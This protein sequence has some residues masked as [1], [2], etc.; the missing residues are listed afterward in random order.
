MTQQ[1]EV[2]VCSPTGSPIAVVP[3]RDGVRWLDEMN[4]VGSGQ[5]A[6][7]LDDA[8][9]ASTP[10]ILDPFNVVKL[11][12]VT[13]PDP[14]FAFQLENLAPTQVSSE[15]AAGRMLT[16]SGRHIRSILDTAVVTGNGDRRTF[17]FSSPTGAWYVSSDWVTPI[18][19]AWSADSTARA[20]N[21]KDWPDPT[22]HWIWSS[23]PDANNAAERNWFRGSFTL[24][25]P[26]DVTIW[27]SC[28]NSMS[29]R[30][31]GEVVITTD[32][33]D[34]FAWRNTYKHRVTLPAGT[35]LVA[36]WVDNA[37]ST[38]LN[39]GAFLCT[40]GTADAQGELDTVILRTGNAAWKVH[41]ATPRPGW[42]AAQILNTLLTEA[43]ADGYLTGVTW[44]FTDTLDSDGEAW[45]DVQDVQIGVTTDLL[46]VSNL[47]AGTVYDIDMTPDLV[48]RLF[49]RMG[50]DLSATVV[51]TEGVDVTSFA[52]TAR[53]G[54]IRNVGL[55]EHPS[56]WAEVEDTSSTGSYG[57]RATG[58]S[59]GGAGSSD[60]ATTT[61]E[62]VLSDLA[63]P[64]ITLPLGSTS[65]VG[66]Q[67]YDD[68]NLG[69]VITAPAFLTGTGPALVISIAAVEQD[70]HIGWSFDLYPAGPAFFDAGDFAP[71]DFF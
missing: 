24:A 52:P 13:E 55:V 30:L 14:V 64:Q 57:K 4:G 50:S 6:I 18:G 35:H 26:T 8:L 38:G 16:V 63:E 1:V 42:H 51:F 20:T 41:D 19:V 37:V 60:Q 69:D 58:L 22:A 29:L 11:R 17:D 61:A 62:S 48:L 10:Q 2:E 53:Y 59:L 31:N 68:F 71:A 33:T 67:P 15:E 36:A 28:D 49:K 43:Q 27:A 66:P 9:L 47:W 3:R 7:H 23:P 56:G 54:Q 70:N 65:A 39:P 40:I 21:P 44:D 34:L 12:P 32:P 46:S 45:D 25:V 5:F